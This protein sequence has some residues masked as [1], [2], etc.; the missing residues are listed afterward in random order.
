M[1]PRFGRC[2]KDAWSN[3]RHTLLSCFFCFV[4]ICFSV[5]AIVAAEEP[6]KILVPKMDIRVRQGSAN[7][8][9]SLHFFIDFYNAGSYKIFVKS[10]SLSLPKEYVLANMSESIGDGVGGDEE[11]EES[12][13]KSSLIFDSDT[14]NFIIFQNENNN[15]IELNPGESKT[16]F[17]YFSGGNGYFWD[18]ILNNLFVSVYGH[19]A[20]VDVVYSYSYIDVD[21]GKPTDHAMIFSQDVPLDLKPHL[22]AIIS[23]S[24]VG[25]LFLIAFCFFVTITAP[26]LGKNIR[27]FLGVKNANFW[28]Y[29]KLFGLGFVV[30]TIVVLILTRIQ[31]FPLPVNVEIN[32]FYG[33]VILGFFSLKIWGGLYNILLRDGSHHE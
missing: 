28:G 11:S 3:S 17:K 8:S 20:Y 13:N 6:K 30:S 12:I 21:S 19:K 24:L 22:L 27:I 25:V 32:D 14:E 9:T 7:I 5:S 31:E 26:E 1:K 23:G 2:F 29:L 4:F 16:F 15:G 10:I 18:N 33:G